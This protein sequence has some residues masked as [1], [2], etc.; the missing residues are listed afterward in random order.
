MDYKHCC[1]PCSKSIAKL[2]L[3]SVMSVCGCL[4]GCVCLINVITLE[5]FEIL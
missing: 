4:S 5:P 1:N 3:F 2:V